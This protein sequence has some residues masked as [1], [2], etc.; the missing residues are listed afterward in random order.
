MQSLKK[1]LSTVFK[2]KGFTFVELAI[3]LAV[4]L[5]LSAIILPNY[6]A[7]ASQF[8]LERS[9]HELSQDIRR[10]AEM[11]MSAKELPGIGIPQ[12]GYGIYFEKYVVAESVAHTIL[13][14]ADR[15]G[16]GEYSINDDTVETIYLEKGVKIER[17]TFQADSKTIAESLPVDAL[18]INFNPPAPIVNITDGNQS[19]YKAFIY[20]TLEND[21]TRIKIVEA[22][23]AGLIEVE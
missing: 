23:K 8:A 6:W 20:L 10:A 2:G 17:V 19:V 15:D 16:N 5:L 12:G 22:N 1:E 14:Y 4:I 13:L 9:S 3:V 18:S 21:P 11:A 7:A